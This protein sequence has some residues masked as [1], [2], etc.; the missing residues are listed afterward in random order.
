MKMAKHPFKR[1]RL[2]DSGGKA[3]SRVS[4]VRCA[5]DKE[6][7]GE[8]QIAIASFFYSIPVK[9]GRSFCNSNSGE[10]CFPKKAILQPA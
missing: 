9:R 3:T 2:G 10:Y 5:I 6:T 4:E 8:R 7:H 1:T